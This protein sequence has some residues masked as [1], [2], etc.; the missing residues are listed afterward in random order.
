[1]Y[2]LADI[3]G[4]K[5]R[6]AGSTDLASFGEPVIFDTPGSYSEGLALLRTT[7]QEVAGSA[8]IEA[9]G[10]GLPVL[11]THDKRG[12]EYATNLPDWAGHVIANDL[13]REPGTRV[14]LENDVAMVGLGESVYGAGRGARV[15]VYITVSTG[16]NGVR[17]INGTLNASNLG[18][19][20]GRQYVTMGEKPV[21][22]EDLISGKAVKKK[23]GKLPREIEK[24][25][26]V[27]EE[28]ARTTAFGVHNTI[29]HWTPDRVVLGGSMFNDI[30]ISVDRVRFYCE[31]IRSGI[32]HTPEIGHSALGAV[33]GLWGAMARLKQEVAH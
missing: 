25:S 5:T 14:V 18:V 27:W 29:L 30:G 20:T 17:I 9:V 21:T 13:E 24:E 32:P 15:V 7:I 11:L 4:T 23:Y 10:M 31:E 1:M 22:W 12:I 3:G 33:G 8:A 28:L 6:I 19:S 26:P 16:V 2:I